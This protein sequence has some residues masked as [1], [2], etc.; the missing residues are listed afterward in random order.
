M[1]IVIIPRTAVFSIRTEVCGTTMQSNGNQSRNTTD[2]QFV[3][4]CIPAENWGYGTT[5]RE[6]PPHS[7]SIVGVAIPGTLWVST[8]S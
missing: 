4:N 1:C 5:I 7:I 6:Q 8:S 3:P 2:E